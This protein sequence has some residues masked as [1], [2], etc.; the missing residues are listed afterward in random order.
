MSWCF[1]RGFQSYFVCDPLMKKCLD[2][3]RENFKVSP[4]IP[5]QTQINKKNWLNFDF[6]AMAYANLKRYSKVFYRGQE[7]AD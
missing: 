2:D 7:G 1:Y 4:K 3:P 6:P 5:G